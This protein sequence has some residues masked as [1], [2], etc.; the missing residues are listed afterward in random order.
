MGDYGQDLAESGTAEAAL[1]ESEA[2]NHAVFEH[3][4]DCIK[5]LDLDG[6]ILS[7]NGQGAA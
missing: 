1:Q 7:M 6:C 4:A 5:V 3:S 2:F